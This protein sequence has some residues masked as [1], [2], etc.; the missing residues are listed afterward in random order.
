MEASY[1][2]TST[3]LLINRRGDRLNDFAIPFRRGR[4]ET[5]SKWCFIQ[6]ETHLH[7]LVNNNI[8]T[9]L[10]VEGL[11]TWKKVHKEKIYRGEKKKIQQ[12]VERDKCKKKKKRKEK[13]IKQWIVR[14]AIYINRVC[15]TYNRVTTISSWEYQ[16][17]FSE[18]IKGWKGYS[19]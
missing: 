17:R 14:V 13:E 9:Q 3:E 16:D 12:T 10:R 2:C 15:N 11:R 6:H 19:K 1:H 5:G 4:V 7:T 8:V 18:G